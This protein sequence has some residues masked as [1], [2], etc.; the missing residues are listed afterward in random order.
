M[1]HLG[2]GVATLPVPRSLKRI[3]KVAE[4]LALSPG[5][6]YAALRQLLPPKVKKL[7]YSHDFLDKSRRLA[8]DWLAHKYDLV[9]ADE[10]LNRM[11]AT[12]LTTYMA[13]D[14]LVKVDRTSMAH[15][16]ECR[17]PLL[18]T[19]LAEWVLA[20][21][22]AWKVNSR[23]GKRLL[24]DAVH[25]RFPDGFLDRPKQGFNVPLERWFRKG[26]REIVMERVVHGPLIG[27]GM[28]QSAGLQQIVD[29]HFSG[30]A[31]HEALVWALLVL[32]SWKEH[33]GQ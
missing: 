18:D 20:L 11:M 10:P 27:M 8:L 29:E 24:L 7:F 26:L 21:P 1:A 9:R 2:S 3:G 28:F 13:E 6:R 22:S 31:N 32:A 17:S 5:Q 16:L 12:D 14:L 25:D 30:H 15:S 19:D 33:S 23:G 4:L